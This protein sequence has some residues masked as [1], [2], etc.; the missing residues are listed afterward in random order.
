MCPLPSMDLEEELGPG[1]GATSP[2]KGP[3]TSAPLVRVDIDGDDLYAGLTQGSGIESIQLAQVRRSR[4][5]W[6]RASAAIRMA[7]TVSLG[8][9]RIAGAGPG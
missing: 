8:L 9:P 4:R 6:D 1:L 7:V 3:A 5:F 2:A